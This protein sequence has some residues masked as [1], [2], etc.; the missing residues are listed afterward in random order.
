MSFDL[1]DKLFAA[2]VALLKADDKKHIVKRST[3]NVGNWPTF[4]RVLSKYFENE[5][6][7]KFQLED[8]EDLQFL[9]DDGEIEKLLEFIQGK[10]Y[11]NSKGETFSNS[12]KIT[13]LAQI[14]SVISA[15]S[16]S[17]VEFEPVW[18]KLS[19]AASEMRGAQKTVDSKNQLSPKEE[20]HLKAWSVYE[21]SFSKIDM[22]EFP[23]AKCVVGLFT[24]IDPRRSSL[25]KLYLGPLKKEDYSTKL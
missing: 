7:E 10:E 20:Q 17:N 2:R 3:W 14:A 4:N 12:Q 19:S 9:L 1:R 8:E 18:K 25:L 23:K 21:Q 6:D 24:L 15:L 16:H 11:K 13:H 5:G 22:N